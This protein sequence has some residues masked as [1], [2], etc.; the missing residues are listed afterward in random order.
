MIIAKY[1]LLIITFIEINAMNTQSIDNT[2]ARWPFSKNQNSIVTYLLNRPLLSSIDSPQSNLKNDKGNK[3][4]EDKAVALIGIGGGI[5]LILFRKKIVRD[6]MQ[7]ADNWVKEPVPQQ[8][9]SAGLKRA[10]AARFVAKLVEVVIVISGILVFIMGLPAFLPI[11]RRPVIIICISFIFIFIPA[12]LGASILTV[13][14]FPLWGR[15]LKKYRKNK[16]SIPHQTLFSQPPQDEDDIVLR[17]LQ[18]E[19]NKYGII[20]SIIAFI[21]CLLIAI[22]IAFTLNLFK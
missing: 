9:I 17:K 16:S 11:L 19:T 12:F 15:K 2:I 3:D 4:N 8:E 14:L 20:C 5:C 22:K 21:A 7:Q 6:I 1:V 13:V 10:D 18:K